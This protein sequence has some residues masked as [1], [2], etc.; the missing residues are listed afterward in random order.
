MAYY[1]L[2]AAA[3]DGQPKVTGEALIAGDAAMVRVAAARTVVDLNGKDVL[4]IV[5]VVGTDHASGLERE[6]K[7]RLRAKYYEPNLK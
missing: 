4:G 3:Q 6:I 7:E 2:V 5:G 1:L